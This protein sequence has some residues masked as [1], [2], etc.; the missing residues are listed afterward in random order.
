VTIGVDDEIYAGITP[1]GFTTF[2]DEKVMKPL[3][4]RS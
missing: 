2:W 3:E 1:D 4:T